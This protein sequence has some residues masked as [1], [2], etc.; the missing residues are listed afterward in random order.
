[1]ED[2]SAHIRDALA[3]GPL[4]SDTL[5]VRLQI[6]RPTMARA[7][8]Q[9]AGEIVRIGAARATRYA[10]RDRFRPLPDIAVYRVTATGQIATMGTLYPVRPDGFVMAQTDGVTTHHEGLPW[11]LNDMRPQGFL[12]RAYAHRHAPS[13]GLPADVRHWSDTD[14]LRALLASGADPVGNVLL[15]EVARD[16]FVNAPAPQA[17]APADYPRLAAQAINADETWS[18]AAG[19][20]PKFCALS[21]TGH[22]LVKF[23]A[24]ELSPVSTRWRDLLLAEH[25]ALETLHGAGIAAARSRLLDVGTQRFLEL[26]RFD[27]VG[28]HG[29]RALI[30]LAS[31]DGEFVGNAN[32]PWPAITAQL[33]KL[34]VITP[35]AHARAAL[36]FAF[37]T[38][39]G[40]TDMHAGNLSF[41]S[42]SGAPYA[43]SPTYDMLPMA[44]SPTSGGVLRDSVAAAHLHGAVD[45]ATWRTAHALARDYLARLSEE[46]QLSPSFKSC[47]QALDEMQLGAARNMARLD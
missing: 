8:G 17:S 41:V 25:L 23:T 30:S 19:E 38:L 45:G 6:S 18:S 27:R 26:E 16:H 42:D 43:L 35:E 5:R 32:A 14:A 21:E 47:I 9:M 28:L 46:E 40:N 31:L 13:L 7:I 29:R 1:M 39:I 20:Q 4:A 12:G 33:A 36:L 24:A 10:L 34:G 2:R 3:A 11:W 37:G 22:V 15:G 44:F